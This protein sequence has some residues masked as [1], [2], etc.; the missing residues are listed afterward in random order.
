MAVRWGG[1]GRRPDPNHLLCEGRLPSNTID[2]LDSPADVI[3]V[4]ILTGAVR[5]KEGGRVELYFSG[6]WGTICADQWTDWDASVVCRQL[7]LR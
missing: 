5:L 3:L 7:G 2:L 4:S 1:G 6:M